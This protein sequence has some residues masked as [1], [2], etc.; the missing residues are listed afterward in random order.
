MPD[1]SGWNGVALLTI[2]G[3]VVGF[4]GR[5][6][7]PIRLILVGLAPV[8]SAAIIFYWVFEGSTSQCAGTGATFHCWE[9]SH[10]VAVLGNG[11]AITALG[12]ATILS[13]A[14]IVSAWLGH[15]APSVIAAFILLLLILALFIFV[16]LWFYVWAAVVAAAI[17]GPPSRRSSLN[18]SRGTDDT[19]A[20]PT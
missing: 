1:L 10:F 19:P 14:P 8:G 4:A 9:E 5:F 13:L 18:F 6:W 3:G 7:R 20:S 12:I 11:Y 2:A 17:A 15:P 16:A